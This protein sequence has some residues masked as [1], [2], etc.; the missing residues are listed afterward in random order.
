MHA[1]VP[2]ARL[3]YLPAEHVLHTEEV[4]AELTEL[5]EPA[6]HAVHIPVPVVRLL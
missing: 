4:V 6:E 2:V 5:N 3:L 1:L